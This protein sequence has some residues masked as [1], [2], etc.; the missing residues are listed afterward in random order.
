MM[1]GNSSM[2]Y[3]YSPDRYNHSSRKGTGHYDGGGSWVED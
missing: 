2:G 1:Y 3:A